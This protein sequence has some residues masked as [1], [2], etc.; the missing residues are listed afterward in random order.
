MRGGV[1]SS[2]FSVVA[3]TSEIVDG[4][5]G[6]FLKE[7]RFERRGWLV[8]QY[9]WRVWG[10]VSDV[11][12][13]FAVFGWFKSTGFSPRMKNDCFLSLE[14]LLHMKNVV[15]LCSWEEGGGSSGAQDGGHWRTKKR[16]NQTLRSA[17][18][19]ST[20]LAA[21]RR[22]STGK[23]GSIPKSGFRVQL[24]GVLVSVFWVLEGLIP[25]KST[26]KK[27]NKEKHGGQKKAICS[28]GVK[29]RSKKSRE[30]HMW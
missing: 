2:S 4:G 18:F 1:V 10:R 29:N 17:F 13:L 23:R 3:D 12:L 19:C 28:H 30:S 9:Y 24:Q 21:G 11:H 26:L 25:L 27:A 5:S 16:R 6:C 22:R 7:W 15:F 8:V 20:S 14:I